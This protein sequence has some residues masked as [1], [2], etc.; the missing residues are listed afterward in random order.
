MAS[1]IENMLSDL[2]NMVRESENSDESIKGSDISEKLRDAKLSNITKVSELENDSGFIDSDTL[3]NTLLNYIKSS[4]LNLSDYITNDAL[5]IALDSYIKKSDIDITLYT[6]KE[7][8]VDVLSNYIKSADLDLS[9]YI[10]STALA[11]ILKDYAKINDIDLSKYITEDNLT[12]ELSEYMKSEDFDSLNYITQDNLAIILKDY[13]KSKDIDLSSFISNEILTETLLSYLKQTDL[14]TILKQYVKSEDIDFDKYITAESLSEVLTAYAKTEDINLDSYVTDEILS[15][16]LVDY[17]KSTDI[18]LSDYITNESL[19]NILTAYAKTEDINLDNYV[20]S[21]LLANTLTDYLKNEDIDLNSYI[22]NESLETILSSYAKSTDIPVISNDLT[23]ELKTKYDDAVSNSHTHSNKKALDKFSESDTGTILYDGKEITSNTTIFGSTIDDDSVS[24]TTSWSS[25]KISNSIN[26]TID[27]Y[28][29]LGDLTSEDG[30]ANLRIYNHKLQYK[31]SSTLEWVDIAND[32]TTQFIINMTPNNMKSIFAL[33]DIENK[34]VKLRWKEPSNTIIE[35]QL[36][37]YV[38][39][40]KIVRKANSAPENISDGDVVLDLKSSD[41]GKYSENF[42]IDNSIEFEDGVTYYYHFYP[43]ADNGFINDS[44]INMTTITCRDYRLFG[45]QLD[46]SESDPDSNISYIEDNKDF[47]KAYMDY[48]AD[49]FEYGD[50]STS[51]FIK[52]LKPCMLNYDGTIAYELDKN[53]YSKKSTGEDSDIANSDF[54]GNAMIGIPTVYYKIEID[55]SNSDIVRYYFSD[56]KVDDSYHC[57]SHLD[58]NGNV[59]EYTYMPIYNGSLV[60]SKLRS[61]SGLACANTFTIATGISYASANNIDDSTIWNIE[62]VGDRQL[63]SLLLILISKSTDAKSSFGKGNISYSSGQ[64]TKAV[65]KTGTM[66]DKGLFWGSNSSSYGVKVF[67]IENFWAN[68]NRMVNGCIKDAN[69]I[70]K[71]KLCECQEDGSTVTGYNLTGD[72]YIEIGEVSGSSD[73][74]IKDIYP[75]YG[76]FP[77]VLGGSSSTFFTSTVSWTST[78]AISYGMFGGS[79][80]KTSLCGLFTLSYPIISYSNWS[81]GASLCCKP[82]VS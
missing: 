49:S 13:A 51:W 80:Y 29:G 5:L 1:R 42:F 26:E 48:T 60:N 52:N 77:K 10:T 37:C 58:T 56:K 45:F 67:G 66:N 16:T 8:L 19:A 75:E 20:T 7:E 68:H 36:M 63:I 71:V 73:G 69:N 59:M 15:Q 64:T 41:F 78:T 57:F 43:Y 53:D 40:I 74:W 6:T 33:Y 76:I 47:E 61:I 23:D 34:Y 28:Y 2:A 11:N 72:G 9:D 50:W 14:D 79:A 22:T 18:N 54:E 62:N 31:D 30:F 12:K 32:N 46:M 4:D 38:S 81:S 65:L 55:S 44:L 24:S 25:N 21:D 3:A 17:L 82:V 27:N 39:G 70:Q 35:N